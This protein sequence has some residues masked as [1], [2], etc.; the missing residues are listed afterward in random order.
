MVDPSGNLTILLDVPVIGSPSSGRTK[1][2]VAPESKTMELTFG[3]GAPG[4][5][6]RLMCLLTQSWIIV[7]RFRITFESVILFTFAFCSFDGV[8]IP[9]ASVSSSSSMSGAQ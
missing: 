4:L 9:S 7:F 8:E 3:C 6:L 2:D 1:F 5:L